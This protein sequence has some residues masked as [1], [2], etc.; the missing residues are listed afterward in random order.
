MK[1]RRSRAVA[2]ALLASCAL[3]AA[4]C[5][6]TPEEPSEDSPTVTAEAPTEEPSETP[7]EEGTESQEGDSTDEGES[8]SPTD[9]ADGGDDSGSGSGSGDGDSSNHGDGGGTDDD[10]SAGGW[11]PPVDPTAEG[12]TEAPD[13]PEVEGAADE[14]I[15]LP[16]DVVVS[17]SA[18]T[19]TT[20]TAETPGEQSG[21]AVVVTVEVAN[22]SSEPQDV[23]SAVVSLSAEDGE[24]GVPTWAAPYAPFDGEVDAGATAEATYVFMLDPAHGRSVTVS[25]NYSAGEPL[26]VFTG[27]IS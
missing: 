15:A 24:V 7:L 13:L 19:T 1:L 27:E 20:L 12:P 22:G 4:L 5:A 21:P 16:T 18:V 23:S 14:E 25:V 17:L 26:A 10:G 6:C 3:A 2:P 11:Q 9:G 8:S